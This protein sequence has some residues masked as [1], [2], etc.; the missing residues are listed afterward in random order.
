M[1]V[2]PLR[3][4]SPTELGFRVGEDFFGLRDFVGARRADAREQIVDGLV[5]CRVARY[6]GTLFRDLLG[7]LFDDCDRDDFFDHDVVDNHLLDHH[8]DLRHPV[9]VP[10]RVRVA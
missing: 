5:E 2:E 8:D 10:V 7:D 9:R 4:R 1:A 3:G 6:R